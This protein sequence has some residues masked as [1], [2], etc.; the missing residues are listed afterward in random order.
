MLGCAL[1]LANIVLA[2]KIPHDA[3][4]P[5]GAKA[6]GKPSSREGFEDPKTV[7]KWARL[8]MGRVARL[9]TKV[10]F[11]FRWD[12]HQVKLM[13]VY[14]GTFNALAEITRMCIRMTMLDNEG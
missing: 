11:G 2:N 14:I 5:N 6:P 1:T 9:T 8:R 3:T 13:A 7:Q 12:N 10:M 4:D